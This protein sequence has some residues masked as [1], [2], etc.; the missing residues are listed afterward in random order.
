M[1]GF[2][3]CGSTGESSRARTKA[4]YSAD[5]SS[6]AAPRFR[7]D[8][9]GVI[10]PDG[11]PDAVLRASD[12]P[13]VCSPELGSTTMRSPA[14]TSSPNTGRRPAGTTATALPPSSIPAPVSSPGSAGD[15]P[16]PHA[17]PDSSQARCQ[18]ASSSSD[19][20][21][22]EYQAASPVAK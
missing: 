8:G 5:G 6:S 13:L 9:S 10:R 11:N 22:S 14:R 3:K 15:S 16:P 12:A 4:G 1:I 18:P 17:A 2:R 19:L 7:P 21:S 20:R